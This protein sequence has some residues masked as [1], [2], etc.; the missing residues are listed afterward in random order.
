M[1]T[2]REIA[3][4]QQTATQNASLERNRQALVA[5]LQP[6]QQG[7]YSPMQSTPPKQPVPGQGGGTQYGPGGGPGTGGP[8][9]HPP[10]YGGPTGGGMGPVGGGGPVYGG[11]QR[12]QTRGDEL[13]NGGLARGRYPLR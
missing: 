13:I 2:S 11:G 6:W 3:Q 5:A 4:A 10:Q 7:I 1:P 8:Q 12:F 9:I